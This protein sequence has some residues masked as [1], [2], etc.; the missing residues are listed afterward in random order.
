M[1]FPWITYS[2]LWT[3]GGVCAIQEMQGPTVPWR[4]GRHDKDI[5]GCS[6]EGRLPDAAKEQRHVRAVF[7]R[8]GFSD[9]ET[10]AL[11]GAHALGRCH[12]TAS[13]YDGPWTFSPT[14]FTNDYYKLLLDDKARTNLRVQRHLRGRAVALFGGVGFI[15]GQQ[16]ALDRYVDV[17]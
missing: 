12:T 4:P 14:V 2:D 5:A 13:G 9:Q 15:L 17:P 11:I 6:P 1:K 16:R 3:L 8:M 7:S 10:V